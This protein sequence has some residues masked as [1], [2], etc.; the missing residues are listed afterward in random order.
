M[1]QDFI[2]IR[3]IV[4]TG[5]GTDHATEYVMDFEQELLGMQE[6]QKSWQLSCRACREASGLRKPA[7]VTSIFYTGEGEYPEEEQRGQFQRVLAEVDE[8][9]TL[10]QRMA[11]WYEML[12]ESPAYRRGMTHGQK[13][14]EP[15]TGPTQ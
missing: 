6:S 4:Q 7:W 15:V 9:V 8:H 2:G 3:T 12:E 11:A 13:A 1:T 5:V 10:H 14:A